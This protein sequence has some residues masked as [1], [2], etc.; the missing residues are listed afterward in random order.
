MEPTER[1]LSRATPVSL[2]RVDPLL[3]ACVVFVLV[4]AAWATFARIEEQVR[5][6]GTVIASS[7]SQ[8]IQAVDG[9]TLKVLHVKEGDRV[10]AGDLIAELDPVRFQASSNEIAAKVASLTATIERLEAEMNG[11]PLVFSAVVRQYPDILRAQTDLHRKRLRAQEEELQAIGQSLVLAREELDAMEKLA[12]SG[13]ASKSEVLKAR[14]QVNDLTAQG[15]NKRNAFRQDAQLEHTKARAEL[16]QTEQVLAQR[17]EALESTYLRAPMAGIVKNVRL[18][19][20]GAV[21]KA[22]DELMQIVPSND[23][24]IVE[25]KVRS[26]DV[27]FLRN[28]LRANVKLD[29][30]DYTLYGSLKGQVVYISPDTLEEELKRDETPYYRVHIETREPDAAG[31]VRLD[32]RPGM[33]ATV[34]IITGE[35][36]VAS[37]LLKPLRRTIDE[38]LHEP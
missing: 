25:A 19:T 33:T 26:A 36:S 22:G 12:T 31:R 28:G 14:R 20:V 18:T 2:R 27:A 10:Q 15:T 17:S 37:Y 24:L 35:R 13:D 5:A 29:A 23:A 16:A 6:P 1:L 21:L 7:R 34:E 3:A 4:L 8:V 9:G 30:Y 11:R 38:S 32:V